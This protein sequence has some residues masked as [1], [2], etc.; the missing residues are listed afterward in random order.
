VVDSLGSLRAS[1]RASWRR[2]SPVPR[3]IRLASTRTWMSDCD[4]ERDAGKEGGSIEL[5]SVVEHAGQPTAS[6]HA[7]STSEHHR[8]DPP[9]SLRSREDLANR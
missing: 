3:L 5:L 4:V 1:I 2:D 7:E 9:R 8:R 6:G